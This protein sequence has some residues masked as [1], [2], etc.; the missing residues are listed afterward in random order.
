MHNYPH[1]EISQ[2]YIAVSD[3]GLEVRLRNKGGKF[4]QAVKS[5]GGLKRLE[6]E[7]ELS[8]MQF[9]KLWPLTEGKRVQKVRY[10]IYH[11]G[12][13]LELDVYGGKLSDLIVA[14]VEFDNEEQSRAFELPDWL[15]QEITHDERYKNKNLAAYGLPEM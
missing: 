3:E 11:R 7:I 15:G 12:W 2:G 8:R 1:Q 9:E 4:T 5:G 6:V 13:T 14:E 10:E